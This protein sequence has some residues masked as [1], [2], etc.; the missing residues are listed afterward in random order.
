MNYTHLNRL[1]KGIN[2]HK[3]ILSLQLLAVQY[4]ID[5]EKQIASDGM[6][7]YTEAMMLYTAGMVFKAW[8]KS[9]NKQD[10]ADNVAAALKT[11]PKDLNDVAIGHEQFFPP[12]MT[13]NI[14]KAAIF[15]APL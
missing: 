14:A 10:L 12:A 1:Q 8:T 13:E 15:E 4:Q 6:E 11:L 2:Y 7:T 3:L 5:V 9:K